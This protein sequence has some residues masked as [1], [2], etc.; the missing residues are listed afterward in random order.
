MF[1]YYEILFLFLL[2]PFLNSSIDIDIYNLSLGVPL[3]I[4]DKKQYSINI[5]TINADY[6][7]TL[8]IKILIPK[9]SLKLGTDGE[10][11]MGESVELNKLHHG[12]I[13][14]SKT[15]KK[16]NRDKSITY[17]FS[18]SIMRPVTNVCHLEYFP[19]K[20]RDY[21]YIIVDLTEHYDLS[22]GVT[23]NFYNVSDFFHNYY[24]ITGVEG[25]QRINTTMI[26][27]STNKQP[28]SEIYVLEYKY[29]TEN[30]DNIALGKRI[31]VSDYKFI[32]EN[33]NICAINFVYDIEKYPTVALSM[34]FMCDLY[35]LKL[36]VEA[37]EGE[38]SLNESGEKN[39]MNLKG[40]Y[41][42]YFFRNTVNQTVLITL[43]T[44]YYKINPID[45]VMIN[46]Y[47][48]KKESSYKEL[49]KIIITNP[50]FNKE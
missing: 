28:F 47:E 14:F 4:T 27:K 46:E 21:F 6:P 42:Y 34:N 24:F 22:L 5:F 45:D 36:N 2:Y 32:D 11:Y 33:E 40:N 8:R 25:F 31:Y 17:L 3:N 37:G 50:L 12:L 7:K 18:Y 13:L 23:K 1:I 20:A 35:Y 41:P 43:I 10:L 26:V 49:K 38:I 15:S 39:I 9:G 48:N 30:L 44:K 29:R 19:N 16:T